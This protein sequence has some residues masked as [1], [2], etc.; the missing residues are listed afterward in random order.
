[1]P[2]AAAA[3]RTRPLDFEL[4]YTLLVL[5]VCLSVPGCVCAQNSTPGSQS[6]EQKPGA[7]V[8]K[9]APVTTTIVVHGDVNGDYL[10]ESVTVGTIDGEPLKDAPLSATVVTRDLLSDQVSRLLSDVVKNDASIGDDYVPVGYYGDYQIRGFPIDLATG[11]EINGM[12]IAGEQDVPLENKERVEF[13]KGLAGVESGVASAG[14]LID[15]VT[16]RPAAIE[17]LDLATDHRGSAYGAADLGRLFG[18]CKQVGARLNLA[19]ERIVPYM[20]DTNG[21]RAVGAGAADWKPSPR[22]ILKGDFEYQHK[23]ERDG[24][25]YQLLGGTTLPDINRI[26]RS[27]MLGDQPWGL[28]DTYDTFNTGARLDVNLPRNW[29]AFAAASFSHSLINDNVLYVY[30]C[31]YESDCNSG[32]APY[33]WF[34]A[35]DGT[36][37]VYDYRDPGELR[38]D[39]LAEAMLTGHVKT[40]AITQDVAFGGEL[41]LRSVQQ[42][43]FYTVANPYSL[44]GIVQDGAVYTYVGSENIYQ[45]MSLSIESPVES[46]GPRRIWEDSHQS[47][48]MVQD[49]IHLPGH[50]QLIA[51]GRYDSLRDHNYSAYA[52]CSGFTQVSANVFETPSNCLPTFTDKPVWLPQFASTYNPFNTLTIYAN[53]GVSLSLGPQGP[54]WTDNGSQFLAPYFARQFEIGAKYEPGQRIL[55]TT[56]FYRMHAPFF[57]PKTLAGADSFCPNGAAGDQCFESEGREA[58]NGAE[59]NAVGKAASWLRLNGSV[60]AM[61]AT[62]TNTGTPTYDNKRVINVPH[63]QASLFADVTVPHMRGL[64]VMPGCNFASSKEATRDDL[65]SVPSYNLLNLGL[66]YTPGGEQGRVTFRIFADNIANKRYWSDTGASYGDT[67]IWLGAPTTVRLSAHYAF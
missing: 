41:F 31:Y 35:P 59:F 46:A 64:H 51:G 11:L 48:A 57:Y 4:K 30:G 14:G 19:A 29:L 1:M 54:F 62:S 40:G 7:A 33:P 63:V 67:F 25:G 53:Y 23:T 18:S 21:W 60:A 43:G 16:K 44:N 13:L 8:Q 3:A 49:R 24:S 55:L 34:F 52:S 5:A 36:Y 9:P 6:E 66:R 56:A 38:M 39:A 58:H 65:V 50:I 42:P 15:Y 20:N 10:P 32:S 17:A 22:A 47:A 26:Y 37:D 2:S 12:T 28:P 61:S 27:T 45:P